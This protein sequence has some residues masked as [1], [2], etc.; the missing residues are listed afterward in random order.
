MQRRM[1]A[2][3]QALQVGSTM[4]PGKLARACGSDLKTLRPDLLDLAASGKVVLSQR[5]EDVSPAGLKGPFR[6]RPKR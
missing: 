3:L 1:L 2:R 4:C 6:V 5:G